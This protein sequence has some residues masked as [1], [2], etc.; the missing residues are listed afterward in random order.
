MGNGLFRLSRSHPLHYASSAERIATGESRGDHVRAGQV[1]ALLDTTDLRANLDA[2]VKTAQSDAAKTTQTVYDG[3][4]SIVQGNEG[5]L[6]AQ[7]SL[8]TAE[9]TLRNDRANLVRDQQLIVQ[10]RRWR[11]RSYSSSC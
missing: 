3:Q 11:S 8:R 5:V 6:S 4:L 1:L 9:Q 10:G 2:A 7:A